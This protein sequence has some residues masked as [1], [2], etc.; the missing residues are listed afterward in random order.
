MTWTPS[1]PSSPRAEPPSRTART[2]AIPRILHRVV[3]EH[4]PEVAEQWWSRFGDL[5]PG[6]RRMT[7]R[8]PLD[9]ADWPITSP[10]WDKVDSGAQLADLVRLEALYRWGGFYVD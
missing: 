2:D 6:W 5:H 3:P 10:H 7:H 1:A 9:P 8:D 4:S